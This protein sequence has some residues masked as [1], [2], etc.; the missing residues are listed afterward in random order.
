MALSLTRTFARGRHQAGRLRPGFSLARGPRGPALDEAVARYQD[1]LRRKQAEG[2]QAEV[3]ACYLQIGDLYLG[4]GESERAGEM[5]RKALEL[6]RR[7]DHA[8][9][10]SPLAPPQT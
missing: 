2:K 7:L 1:F 10:G 9:P 4:C 3:A 8:A 5:Y 6:S